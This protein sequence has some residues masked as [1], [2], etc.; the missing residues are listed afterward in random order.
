M[1]QFKEITSDF[2]LIGNFKNKETTSLQRN[3]EWLKLRGGKYT[4]SELK[5]LM[6]CGR[7]TAQKPWG[8]IEKL[9]DFGATVERY[10]YKVGMERNTG[11]LDMELN[12]KQLDYGKENEPKLVE[13]LLKD[14]VITD[15]EEVGFKTF[16]EYG[17]ASADGVCVY[18]GEKVGVEIKCCTSWDGHYNRMYDAVH[19]KHD[20]FWQ[21]QG[22]MMALGVNKLL[23]A[24]AYPMTVEK[25]DVGIVLASPL[26]QKMLLER[27]KIADK[28]IEL[29]E[30]YP[31]PEALKM[32]IAYHKQNYSL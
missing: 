18:K 26:H 8:A 23:Y 1:E 9:Y 20:D 7:S 22:E 16:Y 14:G 17:G 28:A 30:E 4:G 10:I 3:D 2:S 31:K 27:C 13:Q 15:F 12:A 6:G 19:D 5:K 21:F 29:W 32:A 11:Y 25:Y 24:V